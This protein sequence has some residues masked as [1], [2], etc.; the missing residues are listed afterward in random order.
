[1]TS[2]QC[3]CSSS[4]EL[5]CADEIRILV[6]FAADVLHTVEELGVVERVVFAALDVDLEQRATV[7]AV[8]GQDAIERGRRGVDHVVTR[9]SMVGGVGTPAACVRPGVGEDLEVA[10][11]AGHRGLNVVTLRTRL[12]RRFARNNAK[13]WGTGSKARIRAPGFRLAR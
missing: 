3:A 11:V 10:S 2:S 12:R 9:E 13:T 5:P 6:E 4:I 7:D 1:M 8:F